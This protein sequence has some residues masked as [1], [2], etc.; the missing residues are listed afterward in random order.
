MI[1]S[2]PIPAPPRPQALDDRRR[3]AEPASPARTEAIRGGAA[4]LSVQRF[5]L[6]VEGGPD[7]GRAAVSRGTSI[8]IGSDPSAGLAL[9]D[10]AVSRY[11]CELRVGD[12]VVTVRDLGSRN[13]TT[14]DGVA[15]IEAGLHPGAVLT[16]GRTRIRFEPDGERVAVPLSTAA[17]F[18]RM[19]GQAPAMRAVFA[20]LERAA[21]TDAT[22]LLHGETGT[23]KEAAAESIHAAS[24]R[25]DGPLIVVDCGAV[26]PTLLEAEL[27][28]HAKG[29]FTGAI[30]ARAGAFEAARGGTVF[31]DEI[32]ELPLELQ[33]KLLRVLERREVKPVGADRYHAVDVRVLAA[34]HRDLRAEVNAKRF[35]ADLY[36]RLAVVEVTLPPLHERIGDLPLIVARLLADAP[37]AV[38]AELMAPAF[39]DH[40]ARHR[41]PGNV[42]ELRNYLERCAALGVELAPRPAAADGPPAAGHGVD[43]S[44]PLR[45]A[46]ERWTAYFERAYLDDLLRHHGDNLTQAARAAGVDRAHLYRLLWKHGL[47]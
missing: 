16:V 31:L 33:P 15:V 18:G 26:P 32:G 28:G 2:V 41:W 13:G 19:A 39:L 45:D 46:R 5:T 1:A 30:G 7:R 9:T 42:R 17:A 43:A 27:F 20:L 10:G 8:V 24:P 44:A 11:H 6:R 4:A 14:V 35:R 40:L 21:P 38:R 36:Y 22:I 29:A 23:G 12:G 47:K 37:P 34:S 3:P 25:R